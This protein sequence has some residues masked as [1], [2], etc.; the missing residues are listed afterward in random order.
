MIFNWLLNRLWAI[1]LSVSRSQLKSMVEHFYKNSKQLTIFAKKL[2]NKCLHNKL[3][4]KNKEKNYLNENLYGPFLWMGLNCLKAT[5]PLRK[6]SLLFPTQSPEV[7][8]THS[9][10]LRRMKGC[11]LPW[12]HPAVLNL[13]LLDWESSTLTTA[14]IGRRYVKYKRLV[15]IN[16]KQTL[17]YKVAIT[18]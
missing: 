12:S 6:D 14:V 7:P 18:E 13:G 16:I 15:L 4:V 5:E 9:V 8:G 3:P 11:G 2:H 1:C 10:D 17:H